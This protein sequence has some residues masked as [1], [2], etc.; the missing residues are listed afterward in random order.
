[1]GGSIQQLRKEHRKRKKMR[2]ITHIQGKKA[3]EAMVV[4]MDLVVVVGQS[5]QEQ[6]KMVMLVTTDIG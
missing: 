4:E 1:V 6:G 3:K 5:D 2:L